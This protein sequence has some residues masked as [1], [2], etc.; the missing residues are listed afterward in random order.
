MG[1]PFGVTLKTVEQSSYRVAVRQ[2]FSIG[3]MDITRATMHGPGI[4]LAK[5]IRYDEEF[6]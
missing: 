2:H 4:R 3:L 6:R 1:G 5:W